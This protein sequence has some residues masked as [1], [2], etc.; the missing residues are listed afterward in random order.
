MELLDRYLQA[1]KFWLPRKQ[2]D[3]IIA[4]HSDDIRSEISEKEAE[5]S[6]PL[7]PSELETILKK[8]GRPIL[9]A[10]RYLPQQQLIGPLLYPIYWLVLKIWALCY[11]VPWLLIWAGIEIWKG[12][13]HHP[14]AALLNGWGSFWLLLLSGFAAITIVFAVIERVNARSQFLE[15]W[16]PRKLPAVRD[17]LRIG[18]GNS[19]MQ[20]AAGIVA[21]FGW[22]YIPYIPLYL[23]GAVHLG[24][25]LVW[26]FVYWAAVLPLT[27]SIALGCVN[28]FRPRWTARRALI[29]LAI[30]GVHLILAVLLAAA[31]NSVKVFIQGVPPVT[32]AQIEVW[33][34]LTL[35]ASCAIAAII[36][37][38]QCI[39]DAVRISRTRDSDGHSAPQQA[40]SLT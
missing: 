28:L 8:R 7:N 22:F 25:A 21:V 33:L 6:R 36:L 19:V 4:E 39:Q 34:R 15:E 30:D 37:L 23:H 35:V 17:R 32:N 24:F 12:A 14:F 18:R 29:Q 27:V 11:L 13:Y 1:V 5:L 20:V 16:D 26:R 9:L 40:S 3:D 31:G 2:K 10:Q 38:I